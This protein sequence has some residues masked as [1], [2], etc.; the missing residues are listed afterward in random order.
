MVMN[1]YGY[2][3]QTLSRNILIVK[4]ACLEIV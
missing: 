4:L 1:I 2:L 3:Q